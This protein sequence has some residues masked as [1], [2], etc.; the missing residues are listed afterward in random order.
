MLLKYLKINQKNL[1]LLVVVFTLGIA[2]FSCASSSTEGGDSNQEINDLPGLELQVPVLQGNP[3]TTRSDPAPPGSEGSV[4]GMTIVVTSVTRPA[5]DIVAAANE[6][7]L[8]PK[9][10]QEYILV[11]LEITCEGSFDERCYFDVFSLKLVGEIGIIRQFEHGMLGVEGMLN[12]TEFFGGTV[13]SSVALFSIDQGEAGLI[14]LYDSYYD[15]PL[16]LALPDGE[17]E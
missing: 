1:A 5:N 16:F 8:P 2:L 17:A 15:H 12:D 4:E 10:G 6:F 9:A 7:N 13:L 11:S 14:L 3:E